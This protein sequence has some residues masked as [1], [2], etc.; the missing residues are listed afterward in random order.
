MIIEFEE[1]KSILNVKIFGKSKRDLLEKIVKYP[2]RYI[3]LFRPTKPKAK[4]LQNILQS[5]EIRFGDAIESLL[6]IYFEKKGFKILDKNIKKNGRDFKLDLFFEKDNKKHFI[7]LKIRDDHDSSKKRG[8]IENFKSKLDYLITIFDEKELTGCFYFVDD[9]LNK[10]FNFY[11]KELKELSK[12]YNI[13]LNLFYGIQLFEYF[14]LVDV[15]NEIVLYLEKWK[16]EIPDIPEINFDI[17][18]ES[19]FNEIKDITPSIF[20]KIFDNYVVYN[21]ILKCIFPENKTLLLLRD[22]F[23]NKEQTI[24]KNLSRKIGEII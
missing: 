15:W 7:E 20:Y 17:D 10:N 6:E 8:Q 24:Y 23:S 11:T 3:G 21:D 14:D 22:Y 5:H 1:F 19:T 18:S 13:E 9:T 4:I 2:N 16:S 12:L